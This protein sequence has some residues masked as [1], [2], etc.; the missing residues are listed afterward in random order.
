MHIN[1]NILYS[2]KIK[3]T[4]YFSYP[5][6]TVYLKEYTLAN[7]KI[8]YLLDEKNKISFTFNNIF[9][10]KYNEIYGFETPGFEFLLNYSRSF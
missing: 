6:Q 4:S 1:A 3:D 7:I 8:N 9:N 2:S 10:R 5:Y